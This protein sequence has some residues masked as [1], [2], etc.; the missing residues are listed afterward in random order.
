M[1]DTTTKRSTILSE[2]TTIFE[3][4]IAPETMLEDLAG[5]PDSLNIVLIVGLLDRFGAEVDGV[6]LGKCKTIDDILALAGAG[7]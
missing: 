2:L 7:E 4:E 6:E 1:S 5:W 3:T